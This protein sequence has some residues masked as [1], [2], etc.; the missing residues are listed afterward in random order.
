MLSQKALSELEAAAK[1]DRNIME[2]SIVCAKAGVTTGRVGIG[3][4]QSVR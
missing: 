1:E 2:P 4:A 3:S